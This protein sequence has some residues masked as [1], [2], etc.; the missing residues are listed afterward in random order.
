MAFTNLTSWEEGASLALVG[1]PSSD[2]I[3]IEI[4]YGVGVLLHRCLQ[5]YVLKM[6]I[7]LMLNLS[8]L[9]QT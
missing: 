9:S 8:W 1:Y 5:D 7:T 6:I 4:P 2:G 3:T